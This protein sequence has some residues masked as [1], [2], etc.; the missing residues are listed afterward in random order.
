M[1]DMLT[2]SLVLVI[3]SVICYKPGFFHP[4]HFMVLFT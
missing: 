1:L 3:Y 4:L 2:R